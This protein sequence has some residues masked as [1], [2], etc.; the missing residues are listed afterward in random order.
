[1]GRLHSH[2]SP[3]WNPLQNCHPN[4]L[5]RNRRRHHHRLRRRHHHRRRPVGKYGIISVFGSEL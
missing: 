2:R 3:R 5:H 1:M 4:P